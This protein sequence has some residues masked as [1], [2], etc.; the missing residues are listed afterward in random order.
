MS[1][2]ALRVAAHRL[3][4]RYREILREEVG[5]TTDDQANVDDEISELLAALAAD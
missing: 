4:A 3:R 5:R 2:G 1:E